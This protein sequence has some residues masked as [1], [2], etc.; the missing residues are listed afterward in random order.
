VRQPKALPIK[1]ER[2]AD[3]PERTRLEKITT[4]LQAL[5]AILVPIVVA[6]AGFIIQQSIAKQTTSKDYVS[7]AIDILKVDPKVQD[8]YTGNPLRDWAVDVLT[9][10][11][12]VPISEA[13]QKQLRTTRVI[14]YEPLGAKAVEAIQGWIQ[15]GGAAPTPKPSATP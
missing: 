10:D 7:L 12:P 9:L 2:I 6:V 13:A 5:S 4:L 8:L 15:G 3:K 1:R 14:V 11:S